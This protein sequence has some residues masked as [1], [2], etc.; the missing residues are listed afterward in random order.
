[1]SKIELLA[2]AKDLFKAKIAIDYGANAVYIGGKNYS[3]RSRASNFTID[4]IKELVQYAHPRDARVYVTCNI[5]FHNEDFEGFEDYV[6]QLDDAGVDA[7]IVSS[8]AALKIIKR[9][10]P[11]LPVHLST[12]QSIVNSDACNMMHIYGAD[13]VIL[14]RECSMKDIS[15]IAEKT[16]VPLEV[17]IHG[18][19]CANY[20]GRC[21]LSNRTTNRDA[22]RGG[23][24]HSCRWAYELYDGEILKNK[25]KTIFSMS[26]KDL[27]A[28]QYIKKLM[29]LGIC[30]LKIE[31]RMKSEYYIA[32]LVKTYRNLID[33]IQVNGELSKDRI[34]YYLLELRKAE[35]RPC[36]SGFFS[37]K[38][39]ENKTLYDENGAGVTHE[40]VALVKSFDIATQIATIEIKNVFKKG[41][42][43]EV[44][45]PEVNNKQFFAPELKT[46]ED[47][48]IEEA[49]HPT[50]ILKIEV[51]FE[52]HENDMIRVINHE[53]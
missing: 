32:Q 33:E 44:F 19:M 15:N 1:M 39:D 45:G 37:G 14:G 23:C 51:P 27:N 17:F 38:C 25:N 18:G 2:P 50:Q 26:S 28:M 7:V 46:E 5:V 53:D 13:R 49:N 36:S 21:T 31:G 40:Y 24:A 29:D 41:D 8:F 4:E 43:L 20:S 11:H 42:I 48:V 6:L 52:V 9:V 10:A 12:Q 30:S 22:N 16:I 47:E 35:N 34:T 3:L